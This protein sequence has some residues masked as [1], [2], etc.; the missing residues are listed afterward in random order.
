METSELHELLKSDD[1]EDFGRFPSGR[2]GNQQW[3]AVFFEGGNSVF[4]FYCI[5]LI[6]LCHLSLGRKFMWKIRAVY[7]DLFDYPYEL[8]HDGVSASL[9]QRPNHCILPYITP[10]QT[11]SKRII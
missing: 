4:T 1:A 11:S 7:F 6:I 10:K 2:F 3:W 8:K 5:D 9:R